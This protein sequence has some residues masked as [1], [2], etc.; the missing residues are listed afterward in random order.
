MLGDALLVAAGLGLLLL[1][2][3][4]LVR[5]AVNASLRIGVPPL[6][7]GLTV[8]AFGTSAPELLVTVKAMLAGV[9]GMALGNVVGSNIA[10]VALVLGLPALIAVMAPQHDRETRRGYLTMLAATGAFMALCFLGPLSWPHGL[11]LLAG[12]AWM[13]A[14]TWR[15]ARIHRKG[16]TD[17]GTLEGADP[18]LSVWKIGIMLLA[19]IVGLPI[20]ASL[21][22]DGA[23]GIAETFNVPETVIGL[24]LVAIGTSLPEVA[25]TVVAAIRREI[26]VALGNV[27]GSN[28]FNLLGVI[29]IAAL[30]GPIPVPASV[31]HVDLWVMLAAALI[32]VPLIYLGW[33]LTRLWGIGLTTAYLL[34]VVALFGNGGYW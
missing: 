2:G 17:P 5:G 16:A 10:N 30:I 26:G 28:L 24:T 1:A 12:L 6:L 33:A 3:D 8:V 18:R 22:I 13:L 20:G 27:I 11:V 14:D 31:L 32:L 19:G 34:Y 4:L 15:S 29:G 25:T 21:L 9:P 23:V 7:V